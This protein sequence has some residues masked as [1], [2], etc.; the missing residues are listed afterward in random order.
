M[1]KRAERRRAE[2]AQQKL[3][4]KKFTLTEVQ[5]L[6]NRSRIDMLKLAIG[7]HEKTNV[8]R[9]RETRKN[10]FHLLLERQVRMRVPAL[11]RML[12]ESDVFMKREGGGKYEGGEDGSPVT[13]DTPVHDDE[14]SGI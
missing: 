5:D 14:G 3:L 4:N 12:D 10:Q 9:A 2:K 11:N 13:G 7:I 8:E 6:M 1:S